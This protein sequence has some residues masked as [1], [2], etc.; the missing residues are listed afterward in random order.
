MG[1]WQRQ[2][3]S[4]SLVAPARATSLEVA[5]DITD[6]GPTGAIPA[7]WEA[8]IKA[9]NRESSMGFRDTLPTI[10]G[11]PRS[12][13]TQGGT[14]ARCPNTP[15]IPSNLEAPQPPWGATNNRAELPMVTGRAL[16]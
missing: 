12:T 16:G 1:G 15:G 10:S 8:G 7:G 14:T 2:I 5:N 9:F 11:P 4:L 13:A 3:G 6:L